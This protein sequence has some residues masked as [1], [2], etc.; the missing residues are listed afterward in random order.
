MRAVVPSLNINFSDSG[1]GKPEN[2][3]LYYSKKGTLTLSGDF[4]I[5]VIEPL[6]NQAFINKRIN[7]SDLKISRSYTYE[8]QT[9]TKGESSTDTMLLK[10]NAPA[11][12]T[13][14]TRKVM[15][16]MLN[17]FYSKAVEKISVYLSREELLA[18]EPEIAKIKDIKRF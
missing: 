18:L 15:Q 12:L 6:T 11:Q 8:V 16:E 5:R 10:M 17:E 4:F 13:D 14:D 1:I 3:S 2:D 7:L 9:K